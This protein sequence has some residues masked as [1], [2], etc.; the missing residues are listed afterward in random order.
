MSVALFT[1][2]SGLNNFQTMLDVISNNISNVNTTGFKSSRTNFQEILS[3][4][5]LP[6]TQEG[7]GFGG[8]N[9]V[10]TGV[11]STI[12][13]ID[14]LFSQGALEQTGQN[15]DLAITGDGFFIVDNGTIN[16]YT[17]NG[18][19]SVDAD[20]HLVDT[21]GRYVQ[22]WQAVDGAV[23]VD[24]ALEKIRIPLGEQM[25]AKAT[26]R[27][28]MGGNLD[29][30]QGVFAAG[31]PPTGGRYTSEVTVHDA[32][33]EAYRVPV[34]FTRIAPTTGAAAEW[35]WTADFGGG[36]VGS[37]VVAFNADGSFDV[38][39]SSAPASLTMTP[40][41]GADPF[42]VELDFTNASHFVSDGENSI[43]ARSQDGFPAGTLLSFDINS[44]GL[45]TGRFTNGQLRELGQ[46]GVAFFA[47][48]Q[49]L[50]GIERGMFLESGNSGV[51]QVGVAGTGPRGPLTTGALEMSNVDLTQEFSKMILAQRA[52]QAN[53]RVITTMDEILTEVNNL[54]R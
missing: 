43:L 35:S 25:I 48:P 46:V 8:T 16:S 40:S 7:D 26:T 30:S 41:N 39:N 33:G 24:G 19:F 53:S 27:V 45:I 5:H 22:G 37:G 32:L 1:A 21:G 31:P 47:N 17:R 14:R 20:G 34:T 44:R 51:P 54:K 29:A 2:V 6:P 3:Q 12:G 50:Q 23:D 11:G 10:Q 36:S 52:F 38:N 9:A 42:S 13:A 49:G 18:H 4:T 15:T 28:E